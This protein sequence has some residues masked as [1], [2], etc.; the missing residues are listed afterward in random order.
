MLIQVDPTSSEPLFSQIAGAVRGAIAR[1]EI[2]I[3]ERLPGARQLASSL[4]LNVHTILRGYQELRDEGLVELRRGRGAVVTATAFDGTVRL[5]Q[6]VS[7]LRLVA[8]QLG[9]STDEI[10]EIVRAEQ[11]EPMEESK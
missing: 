4:G 8:R 3:G 2:T 6:A 7:E 11:S 10:V 5:H 9:M 1:G